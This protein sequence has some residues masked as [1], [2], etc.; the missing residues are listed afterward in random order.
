MESFV[1]RRLRACYRISRST[2]CNHEGERFAI[3]DG[4]TGHLLAWATDVEIETFEAWEVLRFMNER[5]RRRMWRP[6]KCPWH[7][8]FHEQPH[9]FEAVARCRSSFEKYVP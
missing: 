2:F 4:E 9:A 7:P 6:V 8:G 5:L 3:Y 1:Q